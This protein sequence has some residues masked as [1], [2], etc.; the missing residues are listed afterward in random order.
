MIK[1]KV[2]NGKPCAGNL[3]V[4]FDEME[5]APATSRRDSRS[6]RKGRVFLCVLFAVALV[7]ENLAGDVRKGLKY[8]WTAAKKTSINEAF[9]ADEFQEQMTW[10]Q[11]ETPACPYNVV[12]T[13]LSDTY[14]VEPMCITNVPV[15]FATARR[16]VDQDCLYIAQPIFDM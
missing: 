6:S 7:G 10:S 11:S 1:R 13:T 9:R 3:H 2:L 5:V 15:H 16:T 14:P 8:W 4:R 12:Q